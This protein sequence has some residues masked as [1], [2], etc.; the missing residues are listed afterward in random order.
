[1]FGLS[2]EQFD[3]FTIWVNYTYVISKG[4]ERYG[5]RYINVL[6]RGKRLILGTK[7]YCDWVAEKIEQFKDINL[8]K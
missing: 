3:D 1:M 4:R 7:Q 2:D 8:I 6:D 5:K